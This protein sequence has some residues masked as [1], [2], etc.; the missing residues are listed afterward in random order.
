M[1]RSAGFFGREMGHLCRGAAMHVC[2]KFGATGFSQHGRHD[3]AVDDKTAQIL[4]CGFFD[5]FL[6][7]DVGVQSTKCFYHRL[8]CAFG[9]GQNNADTL[10]AFHQFNHERRAAH[11]VDQS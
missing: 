11:Q 2:A 3:L 10:S 6:N 4:P 7:E 1:N 8:C 5:K 9:V